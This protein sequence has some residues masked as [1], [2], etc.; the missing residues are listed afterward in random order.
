LPRGYLA[1]SVVAKILGIGS[2]ALTLALL[3]AILICALAP[4]PN[5]REMAWIPSCL[6]EWADRNPNYPSVALGRRG[7]LT[8]STSAAA[9]SGSRLCLSLRSSLLRLES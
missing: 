1:D 5:M 8:L 9:D 6:G 2:L 7:D 3:A 4:S